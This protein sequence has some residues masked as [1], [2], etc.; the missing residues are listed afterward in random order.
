MSH[1]SEFTR[2]R[3]DFTIGSGPVVSSAAGGGPLSQDIRSCSIRFRQP[4][5]YDATAVDT[6]EGCQARDSG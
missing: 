4:Y 2:P 5:Q 6:A 1:I 3:N